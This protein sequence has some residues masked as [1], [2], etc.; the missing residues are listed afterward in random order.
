MT[1]PRLLTVQDY[2]DFTG[3]STLTRAFMRSHFGGQRHS[4]ADWA[5]K[6]ADTHRKV[7]SAPAD[8]DLGEELQPKA[9]AGE[10]LSA[11]GASKPRTRTA[12]TRD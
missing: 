8:A 4:A 1:T 7:A 9:F 6:V 10:A 5:A 11:P 2:C 3:A 12:S